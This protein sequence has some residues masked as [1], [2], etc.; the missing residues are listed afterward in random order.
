FPGTGKPHGVEAGS[1]ADYGYDRPPLYRYDPKSVGSYPGLEPGLVPACFEQQERQPVP[2]IELSESHE[3]GP[4]RMYAGAAPADAYQGADSSQRILYS[5]KVSREFYTYV[6]EHEWL[7]GGN[8][9]SIIPAAA[10]QDYYARHGR[11]PEPGAGNLVSFPDQTMQIKTAWR[12]LSEE[13]KA[14]GRYHIARARSYES[15]DPDKLYRGQT[16]NADFPCYVDAEW[17]MIGMHIKTKTPSAPYY[18]WATF[19]QID[20][21]SD[22]DGEPVEDSHGR[23]IRNADKPPTDPAIKTRNA[24]SAVPATPAT[25]QQMSPATAYANPRKRLH[26]RTTSGTPTTQGLVAINRRD[27]GIPP[28]V[29]AVNQAAHEAISAFLDQKEG[30]GA[31][32][33]NPIGDVLLNYKLVGI[34][35]KPASKPV[36]GEDVVASHSESNP[37]LRYPLVYY[38][39]NTV[40]ETSYR[41]QHY[42]GTVQAHLAP[43]NQDL[44]VQDLITDFDSEGKPVANV[45]YN[46]MKADGESFGFNMGGCMGCHGQMQIKGY[47]FNF[48]FRRGRVNAPEKDVSIRTSLADMVYPGDAHD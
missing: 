25:I 34:Q 21:L 29:V 45:M 4:E 22:V 37:V 48:I 1:L 2:W 41:L 23:L 44:D 14:S 10:T 46:G 31:A 3:V 42:S 32:G 35:W 28:P 33:Q 20:T 12:Q 43:P 17:G 9:G 13:E 38:L 18:L 16:G 7:D 27:H 40:L 39:A 15:Q 24:T 19:E 26:Y 5:V 8:P 30:F 47:D 11:A 6:A 36:P